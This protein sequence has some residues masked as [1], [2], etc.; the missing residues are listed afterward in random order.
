MNSSFN[1]PLLSIHASVLLFGIAGLFGKWIDLPATIIV[2]GRVVIAFSFLFVLAKVIKEPLKVKRADIVK[3]I[4]LG[5]LLALHWYTFF[6]SIKIATV[7]IGLLSF[8]TFPIF[9]TFLEPLFFK[10]HLKVTDIIIALITFIGIFIIVDDFDI[11]NQNTLGVII[12]IISGLTFAIISILNRKLVGTYSSRQ[13]A[14]HQDLWASVFLFP[15]LFID[16]YNFTIEN[17]S[18]LLLLGT[19]FTAIAHSLFIEGL[20]KVKTQTASIIACME[21]V[22]GI[23]LAFLLLNEIPQSNEIIGGIIILSMVLYKSIQKN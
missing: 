12:G 16:D 23:I 18:L 14:F 19:L 2:L 9:T 1:K 3:F 8:S 4:L 22:Y 11:Q 20:K 17:I 10:E 21:P 5:F 15:F 6:Q 13:V 7:A